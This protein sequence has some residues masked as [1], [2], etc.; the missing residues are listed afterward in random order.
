M[1]VLM[2]YAVFIKMDVGC[3]MVMVMM[4]SNFRVAVNVGM[5]LLTG[6]TEKPTNFV[7]SKERNDVEARL[8]FP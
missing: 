7:R 2:S 8:E 5:T 3:R 1:G 4:A 6:A